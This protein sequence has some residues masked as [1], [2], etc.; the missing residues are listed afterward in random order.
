VRVVTTDVG[1]RYVLE[2]LHREG[3]LLGG[4][5]S[6]HIIFLRDHV[7][8]DGLAA[9]LLLCDAVRG[10]TLA[11]AAAVMTRYPQSK[12][13][14]PRS[15]RGPLSPSLLDAVDRLNVELN[16]GGRVLVRP[17]GTEPVIRVLAEAPTEEEAEALCGRVVQ[18]FGEE[19]G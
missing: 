7:T 6:G 8:G 17:S 15:G 2:A 11:E 1:D 3:G 16:G 14:L 10:T 13:N 19:L 12:R 18:L 5:E 9:A 4:E